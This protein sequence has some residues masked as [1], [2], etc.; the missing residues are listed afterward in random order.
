MLKHAVAIFGCMRRRAFKK[1][2]AAVIVYSFPAAT[3][4]A[5]LAEHNG[6][7]LATGGKV[8]AVVCLSAKEISPPPIGI[9]ATD[10][11]IWRRFRADRT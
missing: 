4:V 9:Q 2:I 11:G 6:G 3:E 8:L 10:R 1:L 7:E 5:T